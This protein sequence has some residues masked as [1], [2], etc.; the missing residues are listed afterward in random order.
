MQLVCVQ[1]HVA[2]IML[3]Q[4]PLVSLAP[5]SLSKVGCTHE[6]TDE[7]GCAQVFFKPEG[8]QITGCPPARCTGGCVTWGCVLWAYRLLCSILGLSL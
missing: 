5:G 3:S 6:C 8:L 1:I 2:C 7:L 4:R